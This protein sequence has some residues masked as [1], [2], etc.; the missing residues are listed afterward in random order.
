MRRACLFSFYDKDGIVDDYIVYF[1]KEL[2]KH[3][4]RII[5][6]SNGKLDDEQKAKILPIT[7]EI[8]IRP[9]E[10]FDVMAYKE[11]LQLLDYDWGHQFDEV[12]MVNDTCFGPLFPF[13]ELF[14]EMAKRDCDFWG[15]TAHQEMTP[16]PL[17]GKGVLPYHLNAN[18]IAVRDKMLHSKEF[19]DYWEALNPAADYISA[20]LSHEAFFT[21]KF[22]N[23]GFKSSC[24][25]D[26]KNMEHTTH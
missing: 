20:I 25:I 21:Q 7:E 19:R 9:N 13:S 24:Y 22:S 8:K 10:G 3:A 5:F 1:L 12:L 18:F 6:F 16:N 14:G 2:S 23:L 11:G 26:A 15:V 17:T 4:E